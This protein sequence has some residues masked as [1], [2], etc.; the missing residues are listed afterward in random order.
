MPSTAHPLGPPTVSGNQITVDRMLQEPTRITQML[1]DLTLQRF[2][3]DRVFQSAGG[4]TGGAVIYDQVTENELY[5]DRDVEPVAPGGRFPVLTRGRREPKIAS[6][7]KW[8]GSA[9]ISVEARDRNDSAEFTNKVRAI[10]NTIVR[11]L[12]Q[13]AVNTLE[14]A[15]TEHSRTTVG[16]GWATVVDRG[17]SADPSTEWPHA[18]FAGAQLSADQ[19]ELG[20]DYNLWI[21]NP[22]QYADLL[23]IYGARDLAQLAQDYGIEFY[24]SNRVANGEAYVVARNQVGGMRTEQPLQTR[25]WT[26]DA[27]ERDWVQSSVRPV[28]YVTN[29]FAVLKYTGL[30]T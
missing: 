29:P 19:D 13:R 20:V 24:R 6:V 3:A 7:E 4:V 23:V 16:N 30:N 1:M 25:S 21:L 8:G 28:W 26:E 14:E 10:A 17:S 11:K 18:D 15:V 22:K 2:I 12:N 5:T 27:T 9:W